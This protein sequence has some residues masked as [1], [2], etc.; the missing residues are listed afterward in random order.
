MSGEA[1]FPQREFNGV[2][3]Q[4]SAD[5]MGPETLSRDIDKINQMFDPD[6][7]HSDGTRGGISE[8]NLNFSFGDPGMS[9]KIG[10]EQIQGVA[11]QTVQEAL[12]QIYVQFTDHEDNK[13]NPH[14]VSSGQIHD[15]RFGT[16]KNGLASVADDIAAEALTR[17]AQVLDLQ[18]RLAAEAS[19][20]LQAD[21]AEAAVR[22]AADRAETNARAAGDAAI[23]GNINNHTSNFNNPHRVRSDQVSSALYGNV[24]NGL[25]GLSVGLAGESVARINGDAEEAAK[26]AAADN[27]IRDDIGSLSDALVALA[28]MFGTYTWGDILDLYPTWQDVLDGCGTWLKVLVK[29]A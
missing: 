20:R 1:F 26:R 11:A 2:E 13:D 7:A 3:G 22:A 14:E 25:S 10:I 29:H 21:N 23:Q 19:T 16:V 8:G 17:T 4:P 24:E 6:A 18:G 27:G 28:G 12:E 15:D 5:S 9:E